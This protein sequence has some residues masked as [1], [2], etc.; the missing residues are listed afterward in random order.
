MEMIHTLD[1]APCN[2]AR[3]TTLE[4]LMGADRAEYIPTLHVCRVDRQVF[5]L[6]ICENGDIGYPKTLAHL[7]GQVQ[8]TNT[9][10]VLRVLVSTHAWGELAIIF[11][12]MGHACPPAVQC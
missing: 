4:M 2:V 12:G 11:Q 1:P 10:S 6:W 9:I 7:T 8:S 5:Q 3:E